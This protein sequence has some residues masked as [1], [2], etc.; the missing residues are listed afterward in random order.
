[1]L[2]SVSQWGHDFRPQYL[3]LGALKE[4][5]P[6]VPCIALT[7]TATFSVVEDIFRNLSLTEPVQR[8]KT[9]VFRANLNYE[10]LFTDFI[11]GD[12]FDS[13]T[14]F[15]NTCLAKDPTG[16]G[17]VY[18]R[19]R[20]AC[21]LVAARLIAKKIEAKAYHAGLK[22]SERDEIQTEWMQG[23][24]RVICATIS[25]GMGVDKSSVRFVAHWN[26]PKNMAAYYQVGW[27]PFK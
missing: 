1:M 27:F 7:A 24:T 4:Q 2:I 11:N 18:C 20:D 9:G 13:L 16:V 6:D 5:F 3:Q 12:V 15:I 25:F 23:K 19:A 8:F 10:V 26:M 14:Q 21:S 22:N 17:I